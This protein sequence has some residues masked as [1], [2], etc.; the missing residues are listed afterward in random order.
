M[1]TV[2]VSTKISEADSST[3]LHD[4]LYGY[5]GS[6]SSR[7]ALDSNSLDDLTTKYSSEDTL[8][9]YINFSE[10]ICYFT[11]NGKLVDLPLR[12]IKEDDILYPTVVVSSPG[13]TVIAN[14]E[15]KKFLFDVGGNSLHCITTIYN[16]K[17]SS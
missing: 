9:C 4:Q 2:G 12:G 11:K 8:G 15:K 14:F 13:T 6:R 10:G 7:V 5:F 1:M 16:I 17:Y 3:G